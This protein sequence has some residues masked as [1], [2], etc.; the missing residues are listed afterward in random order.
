MKLKEKSIVNML[1]CVPCVFSFMM[2]IIIPFCFGVY[3]SLTDWN[4][5]RDTVTF[6]GLAHFKTIFTAPDFI[7]SFLLTDDVVC[8]YVAVFRIYHVDLCCCYSKYSRFGFRSCTDRWGKLYQ[9]DILYY[10][11]DDGKCVYHFAF[12]NAYFFL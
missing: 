10:H 9:A 7:Y 11:S 2:I 8:K 4:G 3:Y 5:V 6:V 12:L 1:F